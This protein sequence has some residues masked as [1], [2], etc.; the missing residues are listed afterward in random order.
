M[1]K[2]V[3]V[4]MLVLAG[5]AKE[6]ET[7]RV[8]A[9]DGSANDARLQVIEQ[10]LT[11]NSQND[12]L[13]AARVSVIENT[14]A[15]HNA[16]HTR[17]QNEINQ[18][19]LD[20]QNAD[21]SQQQALQIEINNRIAADANLQA[22][23][24]ALQTSVNQQISNL[25]TSITAYINQQLLA[26]NTNITNLDARITALQAMNQTINNLTVQ[27]NNIVNQNGVT[28]QQ[29][30]ALQ[31]YINNNF[32]TISMLNA[33]T[34][35]VNN[36]NT[37][38]VNINNSVTNLTTLVNGQQVT[39]VKAPCSNAKEFFIKI[40]GK[41]YGAMN[42]YGYCDDL[43]RVYLAELAVNTLY[44]TTDGTNCKFKVTTSGT[45]QQQ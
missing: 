26:V 9:K 38:V 27:V 20:M 29:L 32:A 7:I 41:F 31:L 1:K 43:E 25:N 2:L 34:N 21:Q 4:L 40:G 30:D 22:Q 37:Q 14:L 12:A 3:M 45:L 18:L 23:I 35:T 15:Q 24:Q 33:V 42:Q 10:S 6:T 8:E 28:Q 17:L 11:L 36:L 5:C 13:L 19:R 44:Q 16:E 39:M